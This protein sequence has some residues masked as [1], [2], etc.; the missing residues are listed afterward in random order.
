MTMSANYFFSLKTSKDLNVG[1]S[2]GLFGVFLRFC[3]APPVNAFKSVKT[4]QNSQIG[5]N[6]DFPLENL[7]NSQNTFLFCQCRD[8]KE[9]HPVTKFRVGNSFCLIFHASR[10]AFFSEMGHSSRMLTSGKRPHNLR[11]T[12]LGSK[13]GR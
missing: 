8:S 9:I 12:R 1:Y 13:T 5:R 3:T 4:D 10:L 6:I 11:E 7:E 2:H